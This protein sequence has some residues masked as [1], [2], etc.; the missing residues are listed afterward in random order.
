MNNSRIFKRIALTFIASLAFSFVI[1]GKANAQPAIGG[2]TLE[3]N[4]SSIPKIAN[5]WFQYGYL[6]P[7]NAAKVKEAVEAEKSKM[8][9]GEVK[10]F[11]VIVA[12][13]GDNAVFQYL[14]PVSNGLLLSAGH[15][16]Q[17]TIVI[18]KSGSGGVVV[19]P[20]IPAGPT[21][22]SFEQ[23]RRNFP[24]DVVDYK[25]YKTVFSAIVDMCGKGALALSNKKFYAPVDGTVILLAQDSDSTYEVYSV[26]TGAKD[27]KPYGKGS[28]LSKLGTTVWILSDDK[29]YVSVFSN[30][31]SV[32]VKLGD[33]VVRGRT[34]LGNWKNDFDTAAF[35][36]YRVYNSDQY[37][38]NEVGSPKPLPLIPRN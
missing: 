37:F 20:E 14:D 24:S 21:N 28:V 31:D 8:K 27:P 10:R 16:V 29:K 18:A 30:L 15:R 12:G 2:R 7:R 38:L 5:W 34:E 11:R 25:D 9:Q 4:V 33:R 3:Q 32:D 36:L 26:A 17:E 13:E 19:L 35:Q 1:I 23:W 22:E 6:H